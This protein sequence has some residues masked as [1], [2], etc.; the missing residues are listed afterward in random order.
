[1]ARE[2]AFILLFE[3][4]FHP[5][6]DIAEIYETAKAARAVEEDD[7]IREV[8]AGVT[9]Q[10]ETLDACIEKHSHGWKKSRISPVSLT[11]MELAVYEMYHRE[12]IP[13]LVSINEALELVKTYDEE[14]AR[15]FVN[16]VLNAV[17]KENEANG[18]AD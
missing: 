3:A 8:I 13:A 9:E 16:G 17:A 14:G 12:D 18:H 2:T 6:R 5:E 7:Y 15:A 11:I 10:K 4:K 1:M